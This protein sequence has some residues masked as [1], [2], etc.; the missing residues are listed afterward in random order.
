MIDTIRWLF[1]LSIS[2]DSTTWKSSFIY[3]KATTLSKIENT[4]LLV[5]SSSSSSKKL[6][7]SN[8]QYSII[9]SSKQCCYHYLI[10]KYSNSDNLVQEKKYLRYFLSV[11]YQ[12][13]MLSTK[14]LFNTQYRSV[15][16]FWTETE[17]QFPQG[18]LTPRYRQN[19]SG[20]TC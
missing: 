11:N 13:I 20:K 10:S 5:S 14:T 19:V 3:L 17:I 6:R 2:I 8:F 16:Q 12:K 1:L 15:L 18:S 9:R 7:E 4:W